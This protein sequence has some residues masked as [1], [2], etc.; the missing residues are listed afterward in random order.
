MTQTQVLALRPAAPPVSPFVELKQSLASRVADIAPFVNQFMR[1]LKPLIDTFHNEDGSDVS[2]EI[3]LS[4]AIANAILHGNHE[5]PQKRVYV[6][7][8]CSLNGEVTITV[9]DEGEGFDSR[10]LPDPTDDANLM[11]TH[12]RGLCLMRALMDEV[13]FEE[14]GRVVRMRKSLRPGDRE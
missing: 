11:L 4:E 5:N 1:F 9:R 12:G 10:A 2:I 6:H 14:N 13:S 3:A 8:R 7:C